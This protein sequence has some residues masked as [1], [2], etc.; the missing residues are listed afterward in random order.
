MM[1]NDVYLEQVGEQLSSHLGEPY[2]GTEMAGGGG[3]T[4]LGFS[5]RLFRHFTEHV[6]GG[7]T[8]IVSRHA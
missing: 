8:T 5:L 1:D 6:R 2:R 3:T 4:V 7:G